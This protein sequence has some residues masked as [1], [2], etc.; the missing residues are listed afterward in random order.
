MLTPGVHAGTMPPGRSRAGSPPSGAKVQC[1]CSRHVKPPNVWALM[2]SPLPRGFEATRWLDVARPV[3]M[4]P[5]GQ[6]IVRYVRSRW[7]SLNDQAPAAIV[8]PVPANRGRPRTRG[9][10]IAGASRFPNSLP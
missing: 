8:A 1:A 6:G 10:P 9:L 7:D 3:R 2:S 4:L 5:A